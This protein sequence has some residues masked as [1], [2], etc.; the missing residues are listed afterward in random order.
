[1]A[2]VFLGL[3]PWLVAVLLVVVMPGL[4]LLLQW[5]IRRRWPSLAEGDHN[6]V[7][8]FIIAVVG[9]IYAVLLAFVVIVAFA[10]FGGLGGIPAV[11]LIAVIAGVLLLFGRTRRA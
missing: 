2:D 4:V 7:V 11:L 9:V 5:R 1:M 8:G 6:E 3:P 10:V